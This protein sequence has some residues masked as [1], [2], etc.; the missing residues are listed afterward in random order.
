MTMLYVL[1]DMD[2]R[3]LL[4]R[5]LLC[6]L[7]ALVVLPALGTS[8]IAAGTSEI[9][10]VWSFSG[11]AVAIQ[12]LA[13][14][15]F[16][17]TVVTPTRFAECE[18]PAGQVM[19]TDM[20]PQTDGSFWGLHQW[21]QGSGTT[22]QEIPVLGHTAWR[23][24]ATPSGAHVLKVCFNNPGDET[25]P[26]IA[27]NGKE[28]NVTYGCRESSPLAPLPTV[29]EEGPAKGSGEGSG[30]GGGANGSSGDG[31]GAGVIT[32]SQTVVLPNAKA[33]VS[34]ASLKIKLRDPKYDPLAEVLV[35]INRKKVADVKGVKNLKKGIT[36]KKLP[37]GTYKISV[38]ATT[39]LKQRLTGSQTYKSCIKGS[40]KIKLKRVKGHHA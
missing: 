16:Q 25:Q 9:E 26:T 33:C 17:G 24:L 10:E 15:T 22:C 30:N 35:K 28:E 31:T 36:L 3:S 8:A 32:F 19:W 38:V 27:P 18:H 29:S 7:L 6:A 23:V 20:Q 39:V 12:A 4:R 2:V 34:Q 5:P 11:G 13:D 37:T 21:Y 1:R 40:G 14:G